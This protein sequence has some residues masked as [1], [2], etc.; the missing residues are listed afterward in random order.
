MA[1]EAILLAAQ[2]A[3]ALAES[4]RRAGLRPY[5]ADLFGDAD[6]LDLAEGYRPLPGRFGT[7]RLG[8]S[9]LIGALDALAGL[10]GPRCLGV[11]L[12]SG[13]EGAPDL[14]AEIA[15]RHRLLGA[16][17]G[18]V[19]ALKDPMGFAALCG[20]LG[21]PHP[22][23]T[24]GPLDDP[25]GWL[26]KRAG[27]SGG[28]HI[29]AATR[30]RA[31]AGAYFQA[32]VPGRAFGLAVLADGRSIAVVA[33]TEQWSAGSALRPHRYAGAL[34]RGRAEA[35]ALPGAILAAATDAVDR[36]AAATG[37]RGL[38][39]ADLLSDG[40]RWW[41]TEINPRPGA[42]L[43]ILD[44]RGGS[45]LLAHVA[46]SAGERVTPGPTPVDAAAAEICY[47]ARDYRPVPRIA[48]PDHA[49]DRPRAGTDV[50]RDAPLCTLLATGRDAAA[51]REMLRERAARLH[52]LLDQ[53][54]T[55]EHECEVSER[56]RADGAAG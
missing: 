36:L 45:L 8:G 51:V 6:T 53:E 31:P 2:S 15:R 40:E 34:E 23:V 38:A 22:A 50:A 9:A 24:L 5:V 46:A 48:W 29:R 18:T 20:R 26:L 3:R 17:P 16:A 39:S 28:S 35:P 49:R 13:L 27:G 56:Q 4:A 52:A 14:M 25:A 21:I 37:L 33:L 54:E 19:A 44:R 12:G 32:R 30:G 41:L 43:D 7:G 55:D 10:A 42:T 1:G 47:G 11:V